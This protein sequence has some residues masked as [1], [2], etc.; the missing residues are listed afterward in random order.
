MPSAVSNIEIA[1][2][3]RRAAAGKASLRLHNS[4]SWDRI[5]CGNVEFEIDGYIVVVFNDCDEL[6]YV[7][8]ARAPDG[9]TGELDG[10]WDEGGDPIHL[11]TPEEREAVYKAL[12]SPSLPGEVLPDRQR[13]Q[14]PLTEL[15]RRH[16]R[17]VWL[18]SGAWG[19]SV[20]VILASH[21][22]QNQYPFWLWLALLLML[23]AAAAYYQRAMRK[24]VQA[25]HQAA[26]ES[27]K[28]ADPLQ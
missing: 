25:Q 13:V 24:L 11:L 16:R 26:H 4:R 22:T 20:L 2:L 3:L 19:L 12:K 21:V 8:R 17:S 6:D 27:R 1:D 10:W 15:R 14:T 5:Y 23:F 28:S 9:R 18:V 7:D